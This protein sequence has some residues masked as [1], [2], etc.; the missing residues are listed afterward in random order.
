M[1]TRFDH[2]SDDEIERAVNL[3]RSE[4][5]YPERESDLRRI[6]HLAWWMFYMRAWIGWPVTYFDHEGLNYDG[7]HRVR[8][9]KFLARTRKFQVQIP[10]RYSCQKVN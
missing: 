6:A 1:Q 5:R 10:V 9:A 7:H 3:V 2:I 4:D 8:A